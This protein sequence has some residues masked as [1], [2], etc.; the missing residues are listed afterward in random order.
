MKKFNE[1]RDITNFEI[2]TDSGWQ[3][4][5]RIGKTVPYKVWRI[6]TTSFFLEC[7][8][9]HMIINNEFQNVFTK[10]LELGD[11]VQTKNGPEPIILIE[12]TSSFEEMFDLE[13]DCIDH[14]YYTNG[15]LSHNTSWLCH[16]ASALMKLG[17]NVLYASGEMHEGEILRRVDANVLDL[18]V[19]G[20]NKTLDK[21]IF[22][23][24][25][26]TIYESAHGKLIVK[27]FPT[28]SANSHHIKN[29]IS[30]LKIKKG[31]VPDVVILD[32]LNNFSSSKL[33][34]SQTGTSIYVKSVAEEQRGLANE[35][36]YAL[37][38]VAQFNRCLDLNTVLQKEENGSFI[39][40][41]ISNIKVGD[42]IKSHDGNREVLYIFPKTEQK[43]Y[44]IKTKSGKEIICSGN[45]IFPTKRGNLCIN[46]GLT[47]TD[48]LFTTSL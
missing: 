28:G 20:F 19:N 17:Y 40:I 47:K 16:C 48:L 22:T 4:I 41:P 2:L 13:V 44:K 35:F 36:D 12:E 21:K 24:R 31:F 10:D 14:R 23:S 45:H 25:L 43:T 26:K 15:I 8:D 27:D 33:P 3:S 38:T 34:A 5:N 1:V 42:K 46:N 29:V 37:L 7:A 9:T 6:K 39:D 32:G 18:D 30:E 11:L